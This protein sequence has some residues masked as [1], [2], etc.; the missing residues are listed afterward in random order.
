ML[1]Y[2][3]YKIKE[4]LEIE[5]WSAYKLAN[6]F[7]VEAAEILKDLEII[8]RAIRP[9]RIE[10][11]PAICEGCGFQ[12]RNRAKLKA[13]TKCPKCKIEAVDDPLLYIK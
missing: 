13:P 2:R 6:Y 4:M 1:E 3:Q 9:K 11:I 10:I 7:K 5:P 12:F 8:K